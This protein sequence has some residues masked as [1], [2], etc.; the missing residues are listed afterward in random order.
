[1]TD[2]GI[3]EWVQLMRNIEE[4]SNGFIQGGITTWDI[5]QGSSITEYGVFTDNGNGP[6]LLST[7]HTHAEATRAL[8]EQ[9]EANAQNNTVEYRVLQRE[10]S[11]WQ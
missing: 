8:N 3:P 2:Q 6:E 9:R 11:S 10:I 4:K 1:M 7:H 5:Q